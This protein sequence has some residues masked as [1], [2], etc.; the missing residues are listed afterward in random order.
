MEDH[1]PASDSCG[2]FRLLG[3]AHQ[4]RF[5]KLLG[6]GEFIAPCP[7]THSEIEPCGYTMRV[8]SGTG[9]TTE[10]WVWS[11]IYLD[12]SLDGRVA[13]AVR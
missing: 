13:A 1:T 9:S 3:T 5:W 4:L 2:A 6:Q 12:K 10:S 7:G 11:L 8:T